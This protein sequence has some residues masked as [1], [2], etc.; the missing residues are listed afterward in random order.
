[1]KPHSPCA[2]HVGTHHLGKPWPQEVIQHPIS[3]SFSLATIS[4]STTSLATLS[5]PLFSLIFLHT[6]SFVAIRL[7]KPLGCYL[8]QTQAREQKEMH[9]SGGVCI[10]SSGPGDSGAR[11]QLPPSTFLSRAA[12]VPWTQAHQFGHC[13]MSYLLLVTLST[14]ETATVSWNFVAFAWPNKISFRHTLHYWKYSQWLLSIKLSKPRI[15]E[16]MLLT[17]HGLEGCNGKKVWFKRLH[18]LI[19]SWK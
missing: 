19:M 1:M 11:L 2:N 15:G 10:W 14:S 4:Y 9:E 7:E 8:T 12:E 3:S 17:L 16:K 5:L 18:K 6:Q 13:S